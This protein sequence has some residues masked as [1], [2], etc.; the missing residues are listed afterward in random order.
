VLA[1]DEHGFWGFGRR[2]SEVDD[3]AAAAGRV[4]VGAFE[5]GVSA[6]VGMVKGPRGT[7]QLRRALVQVLALTEDKVREEDSDL[8]QMVEIQTV[9]PETL[10]EVKEK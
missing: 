1:E 6:A 2:A 5:L 9:H 7:G 3:L 4:L 10:C 8:G